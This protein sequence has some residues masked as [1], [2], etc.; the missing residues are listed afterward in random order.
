MR[1]VLLAATSIVLVACGQSSENGGASEGP[2]V[3]TPP[4]SDTLARFGLTAEAE[5]LLTF[6]NQ[7]EDGNAAVF[8]N[9]VV[10][11]GPAPITIETVRLAG[12][13]SSDEGV[14]FE[15]LTFT[16]V[17]L[18]GPT[19][20]QGLTVGA[21]T[22]ANPTPELADAIAGVMAGELPA[23][24]FEGV[25]YK[26]VNLGELGLEKLIFSFDDGFDSGSV[27]I[28]EFAV[29]DLNAETLGVIGMNAL[30]FELNTYDTGPISGSLAEI[31][32]TGIDRAYVSS[33][34]D[35]SLEGIATGSPE[36]A[37]MNAWRAA[38]LAD[39]HS[40]KLD[41]YAVKDLA[42]DLQGVAATLAEYTGTVTQT[43]DGVRY[44]ES[45]T[46]LSIGAPDG[47]GDWGSALSL[48]L[49]MLGYESLDFSAKGV[50]ETN[51][52]NDS[53]VMDEFEFIMNDGFTLG[54]TYD[55]GGMGEYV[56]RAAELMTPDMMMGAEPELDTLVA[57]YE[58]L[59]FNAFSM[60]LTDQG[61][62]D[63]A[64][65]L[66][67]AQMNSDAQS[68]RAM[69][70]GFLPMLAFQAPTPETQKLAGSFVTAATTFINEP[71]TSFSIALDPAEPVQFS[72]VIANFSE[73]AETGEDPTTLIDEVLADLNVTIAA[74]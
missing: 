35:A 51:R 38:A 26:A 6:E 74:E 64:F 12:A 44:E 3:T 49:A 57:M 11:V 70:T 50:V 28:G 22:I 32:F 46:G 21:V 34:I 41:G 42:F 72:T 29:Q 58:P 60:N 31:S 43:N 65:E 67:G 17:T 69:A 45:L 66:I 54:M 62:A 9:A 73:L 13:E 37:A 14:A 56:K 33:I 36:T 5:G 2:R 19:D 16:N 52:A 40:K 53:M 39:I 68:V 48:Q 55:M 7:S 25:D 24:A 15:S 27:R 1:K 71:G 10:T 20:D 8:E 59:V 4:T 23:Q 18:P 63:R 61:L 47:E 30:N